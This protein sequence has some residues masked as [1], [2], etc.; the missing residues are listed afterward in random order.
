MY[1]KTK[2]AWYILSA[3]SRPYRLYFSGFWLK[4]HILHLLVVSALADPFITLAKFLNSPDIKGDTLAVS[5][6][7]EK[8]LTEDDILSEDMV[9]HPFI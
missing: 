7:L 2:Y 3:P 5:Q 8:P 6:I 4:H 9:R 1:L